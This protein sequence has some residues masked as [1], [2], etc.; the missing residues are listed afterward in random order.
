L[1]AATCAD[2]GHHGNEKETSMALIQVT[3]IEGVFTPQQKEEII[4]RLT[5]AMV[6]IEGEN[7]RQMISCRRR[8]LTRSSRSGCYATTTKSPQR[9][10]HWRTPWLRGGLRSSLHWGL[11]DGVRFIV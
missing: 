5:V 11:A 4:E 2:D 10:M 3:L 6:A 8:S 7:M 9:R 1:G